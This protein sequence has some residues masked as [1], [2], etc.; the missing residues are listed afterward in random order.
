MAA[1]SILAGKRSRLNTKFWLPLLLL[2]LLNSGSARAIIFGA[3]NPIEIKIEGLQEKAL[4][5]AYASLTLKGYADRKDLSEILVRHYFKRGYEEIRKSLQPFG[6]Y[7]VEVRGE[8]KRRENNGW[9]GHYWVK[10]GDPVRWQALE[11][12]LEGEGQDDDLLMA[13]LASPGFKVGDIAT[14]EPYKAYKRLML[15]R[16]AQHGYFQASW[17]THALKVNPELGL[18]TAQLSL[19]TGTRYRFG[20]LNISATPLSDQFLRKFQVWDEGDGFAAEDVLTMRYALADSEYFRRVD[21]APE[22]DLAAGNEDDRRVPIDVQLEPHKRNRYKVG[23]GYGTDTGF[24]LRA[25]WVRRWVNSHGHRFGADFQTSEIADDYKIRYEIPRGRP[26]ID[27]YSLTLNS[28]R[29]EFP[30]GNSRLTG[31]GLERTNT[32]KAW[33]FREY[34]DYEIEIFSAG[35]DSG[36]SQLLIPGLEVTRTWAD[37]PLFPRRGFRL[38]FDIH[39]AVEQVASDTGFLQPSAQLKSVLGLWPRG[40]LLNRAEIGYSFVEDFDSL[41]IS[42]RFFVGG[43]QSVRGFDFR[44]I[45]PRDANGKQLGGHFKEVY[46]IELEQQVSEN[47]AL[48]AFVDA[49]DAFDSWP[50]NLNYGAGLGARLRLPVGGLRVD[51]AYPI[52]SDDRDIHLHLSIGPDL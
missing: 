48:A 29:E 32:A 2:L 34:L 26:P 47:W 11:L 1:S 37:D 45:S 36:Q 31:V 52:N 23:G 13:R 27:H 30:D 20:P 46:S 42:Q 22:I 4:A 5:N 15:E 44:E 9:Q 33:K 18:A 40:R 51:L 8:L 49:G 41:P 50:S 16:A 25:S 3:Q 14:H 7:R 19:V 43:G 10:P 6:Y 21:V 38:V 28:H 24:R 39:G 17:A 35:E 12:S